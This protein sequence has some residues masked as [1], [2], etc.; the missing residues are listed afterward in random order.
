MISFAN[1]TF[2]P[3]L[4]NPKPV[5]AS[6]FSSRVLSFTSQFGS[7]PLKTLKG[8]RDCGYRL[9]WAD[10]SRGEME[11][12][13]RFS[14]GCFFDLSKTRSEVELVSVEGGEDVFHS[15]SVDSK[16]Q[17]EHLVIMVNGLIGSAADW[18]YAAKQFVRRLPERVVV[19]CSE[20]NYS[21]LTFDGVDRMG[22]RLAEEVVDVVKRWPG[23]HKISF[24]SHSLGGLVARYA[25]GRLFVHPSAAETTNVDGRDK[26]DDGSIAGLEPMNFITVATPHLGSRGHKQLPL[27]CGLPLL[28]KG[29]SQTAHL[30]VGRSG[31]H[32]F[33][34]DNDD[35]KPP[36]LL[37]MANDSNDLKFISALRAFKRR[38]VYA[39]A[40]YDHVV[41]WR[42]SSI[43]RQ[44]ELPKANILVKDTRYPHIVH[45][46]QETAE[47]KHIASSATVT[48]T[49]DLEG[50]LLYLALHVLF[51]YK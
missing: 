45:V 39:N 33:L 23:M 31:K 36:L 16:V 13:R 9:F 41:G 46:A 35:G 22:D 19:H 43:R 14:R 25:V 48:K 30:L 2:N 24:V 1:Q 8:G 21:R 26:Y 17:P 12:V 27:L 50:L 20:C 40:N 49:I 10:L 4:S 11:L 32:L 38:V 28:E 34:T 18:R 15:S 29:V 7:Q 51:I 42:T 5:S 47:V 37:R 6:G 3:A 44:S